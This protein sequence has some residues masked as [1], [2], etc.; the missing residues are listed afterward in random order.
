MTVEQYSSRFIELV[1]FAANLIPDKE[2]K[3]ECF[4]NGLNPRIKER[5]IWLEIKDYAK[6]VE[7]ESLAEKGIHEIVAAYNLKRQQKQ[8]TSHS[9]KRPMLEHDSKPIV[10]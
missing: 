1:R 7:V 6:L 2:S 9:E 8:Q 4:E 5:V 10:G 3:V